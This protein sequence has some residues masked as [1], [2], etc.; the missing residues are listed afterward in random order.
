LAAGAVAYLL[1]PFQEH[2][3]MEAIEAGWHHAVE[4]N[5]LQEQKLSGIF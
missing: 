2:Q 4:R 5:R 3:I 1:K